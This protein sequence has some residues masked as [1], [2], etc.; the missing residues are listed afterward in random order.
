MTEQK[1][2]ALKGEN[3][4]LGRGGLLDSKKAPKKPTKKIEKST[5]LGS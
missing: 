4:N 5:I 1:E 3:T 2:K